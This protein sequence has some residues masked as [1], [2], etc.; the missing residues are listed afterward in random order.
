MHSKDEDGFLTS[1]S[2]KH[3]K[4]RCMVS[5][6]PD[7]FSSSKKLYKSKRNIYSWLSFIY[8]TYR[9]NVDKRATI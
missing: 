4:I 3:Y 7:G 6:K 8:W 2:K 9:S 1:S 5:T